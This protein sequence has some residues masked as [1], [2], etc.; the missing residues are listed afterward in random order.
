MRWEH[1]YISILYKSSYLKNTTRVNLYQ[2]RT[3][4]I[5][6][7]NYIKHDEPHDIQV[8]HTIILPESRLKAVLTHSE[9]TEAVS[10]QKRSFLSM[11]S[12]KFTIL[13]FFSINPFL[14]L[15]KPRGVNTTKAGR[16]M[17]AQSEKSIICKKTRLTALHAGIVLTPPLIR[18]DY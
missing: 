5:S 14:N 6:E 2:C 13:Q 3:T 10:T 8:H 4:A 15:S 9:Q 17:T 18:G 16:T 12:A 7:F 1:F 11:H